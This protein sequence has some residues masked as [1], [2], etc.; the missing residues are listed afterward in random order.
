MLQRAALDI[1]FPF[2]IQ[3]PPRIITLDEHHFPSADDF[4]S[5]TEPLEEDV[6]TAIIQ[7]KPQ[8]HPKQGM[9]R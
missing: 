3:T 9:V 7:T 6:T 8:F 4:P 2:L 5:H 1:N